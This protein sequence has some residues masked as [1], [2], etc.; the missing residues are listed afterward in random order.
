M[1]NLPS[2]HFGYLISWLR[3]PKIEGCIIESSVVVPNGTTL[4]QINYIGWGW[5]GLCIAGQLPKRTEWRFLSPRGHVRVIVPVDVRLRVRLLSIIGWSEKNIDIPVTL[6][7]APVQ[8]NP[9][10]LIAARLTPAPDIRLLY[11]RSLRKPE[12]VTLDFVTV[13]LPK[14][15][16]APL[17]SKP[18]NHQPIVVRSFNPRCTRRFTDGMAP[19]HLI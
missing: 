1:E 12:A 13:K 19:E 9:P 7:A 8:L 11:L 6:S 2:S 3:M 16:S 10:E 14:I 15:P 4:V 5:L 17:F 18:V